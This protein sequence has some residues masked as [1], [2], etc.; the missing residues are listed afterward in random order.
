[1]GMPYR[2]EY[3]A[4]VMRKMQEDIDDIIDGDCVIVDQPRLVSNTQQHS[5]ERFDIDDPDDFEGRDK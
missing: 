2:G 4:E 5:I 3:D 1:M